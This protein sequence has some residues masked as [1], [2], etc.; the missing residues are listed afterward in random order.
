MSTSSTLLDFSRALPGL[1]MR[2][3]AAFEV[4]SCEDNKR[5]RRLEKPLLD[6]KAEKKAAI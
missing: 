6:S 2:R 1:H 4:S 5:V 3:D